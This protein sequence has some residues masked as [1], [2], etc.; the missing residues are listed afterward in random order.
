MNGNQK[1]PEKKKSLKMVQTIRKMKILIKFAYLEYQWEKIFAA[2]FV[3]YQMMEIQYLQSSSS[4][5]E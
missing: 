4:S 2:V 1:R 5:S 3:C